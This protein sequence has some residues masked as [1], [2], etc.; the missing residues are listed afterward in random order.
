MKSTLLFP[1]KCL[2]ALLGLCAMFGRQ[3]CE[4]L[5]EQCSIALRLINQ[6]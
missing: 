3:F 5:G 4:E 2:I 1:L 6:K